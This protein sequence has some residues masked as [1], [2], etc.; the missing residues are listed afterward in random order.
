MNGP[1]PNSVPM[2][3]LLF[4]RLGR[5]RTDPDHTEGL[6]LRGLLWMLADMGRKGGG[7]GGI[8]IPSLSLG[9]SIFRKSTHVPTHDQIV[10]L[11]ERRQSPSICLGPA[12][13]SRQRNAAAFA[14]S[15][16]VS[17]GGSN[18]LETPSSIC[19]FLITPICCR[20]HRACPH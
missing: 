4:Q 8:R 11:A 9:I 15:S 2:F 7:W 13:L 19:W 10:S 12:G 17:R 5:T 20:R 18:F 16:R 14:Q 1:P 6:M 3:L